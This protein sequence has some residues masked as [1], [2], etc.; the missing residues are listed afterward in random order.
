M[1]PGWK[2]IASVAAGL[3]SLYLLARVLTDPSGI[4]RVIKG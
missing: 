1:T 2:L 4:E 3:A